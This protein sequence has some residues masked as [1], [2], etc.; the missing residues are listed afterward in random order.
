MSAN[1]PEN[2]NIY[3]NGKQQVIEL[4]RHMDNQDKTKL[5]KNLRG[6]NPTL[7]RELGEQC[8]SYENIWGLSDED[9][10]RVLSGIKPVILGLALNQ[11]TLKNQKRALSLVSRE[12]AIKAYEIMTKDLTENRREC[13]RA[14]DKILDYALE[15]QRNQAI[16]FF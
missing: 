6:R 11:S 8:L 2:N 16:R 10:S 12:Q 15:L 13:M 5:L 7:A 9:L 14:Q 1:N 3:I 4:L